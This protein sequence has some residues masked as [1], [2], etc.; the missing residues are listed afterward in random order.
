MIVSHRPIRSGRTIGCNL[1]ILGIFAVG[2]CCAGIFYL[3]QYIYRSYAL[4]PFEPS[5]AEFV[6]LRPQGGEPTGHRT[7]GNFVAIDVA[8]GSFDPF[9]FDLPDS[10]KANTP[11]DVKTVI[12]MTWSKKQ[13]HTYNPGRIPGYTHFCMVEVVDRE[14]KA[15]LLRQE[16]MG[17]SPPSSIKNSSDAEGARPSIGIVGF[18]KNNTP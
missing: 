12:F 7:K 2:S 5:R 13:T 8:D 16:F 4:S 9:N 11:A 6:A 17:P 15:L 3:S 10:L 18:L 1:I 14:T